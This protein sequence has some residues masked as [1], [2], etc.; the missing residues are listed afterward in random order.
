MYQGDPTAA[1]VNR[2]AKLSEWEAVD[3]NPTTL[4]LL[5]RLVNDMDLLEVSDAEAWVTAVSALTS[6]T[7]LSLFQG[8]RASQMARLRCRYA[9][10]GYETDRQLA[11][12]DEIDAVV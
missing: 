8:T 12:I 6:D 9:V 4:T 1:Q 2:I 7:A 11:L 3:P 5:K 10:Y